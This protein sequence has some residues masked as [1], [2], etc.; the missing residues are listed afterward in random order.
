MNNKSQLEIIVLSIK[1]LLSKPMLKIAFFPFI[2][3]LIVIYFAFFA[4]ADIGLDTLQN[5]T[6]QIQTQESSIQNGISNVETTNQTYTGY[7]ILDFLLKYSITSWIVG[8][9]VYTIGS[10]AVLWVSLFIALIIVGFLTPSILSNL[11]KKYYPNVK[12]DGYGNVATSIFFLI[13]NIFIMLLLFIVLTPLYFIPLVNIVAINIPFYY[14]F[15]KMLHFDVGSTLLNKTEHEQLKDK[16]SFSFR[17][18]TLFLYLLSMIPFVALILP[19]F[20]IIYLGHNYMNK[21]GDSN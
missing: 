6:L 19:V 17:M 10:F 16:Y 8:F 13:K 4:I 11:Q 18:Q 9:L 15:H 7:W 21:L 3:T 1:D 5:T 20:Y 2:V 14:F 12:L